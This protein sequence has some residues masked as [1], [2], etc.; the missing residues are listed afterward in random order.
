[1]VALTEAS[2]GSSTAAP[3]VLSSATR[4]TAEAT[5][6]ATWKDLL[7]RRRG[8]FVAAGIALL[9]LAVIAIGGWP[10][11]TP[12]Q[13]WCAA[14]LVVLGMGMRVWARC[15][16][17]RGS[18]T[19]RVHARRL[20]EGGPYRRIRN[21]VYFGN[22]AAA[23]GIA[24]AF[25][26]PLPA[27]LLLALLGTIYSVVVRSEEAVLTR[28]FPEQYGRLSQAVPRWWPRARLHAPVPADDA[29]APAPQLLT[30]L[31]GEVQRILG[32]GAAWWIALWLASQAT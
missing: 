31:R 19:R 26:G 7:F 16:L 8:W 9:S 17:V 25:A 22:V 11:P 12:L 5:P 24:L 29:D 28:T 23:C 3:P 27:A 6:K 14:P 2:P 30:A 13:A 21:P 32:A 18:N 10:T 20:V 1:M 15:Y 4:A